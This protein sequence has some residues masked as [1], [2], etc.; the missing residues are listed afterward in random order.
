MTRKTAM[1]AHRKIYLHWSATDYDWAQPGHYHSVVNGDGVVQRMHDYNMDLTAHT[2]HRNTNSIGIACACMGGLHDPWT[3]PPKS[4]QL[5][6]MCR[7]VARIITNWGWSE[8]E[9]TVH[10]ILTHA[11]AAANRDGVVMHENYGPVA[12]G[13]TGERWDFMCLTK[14]GPDTGGDKI[15]EM[16]RHYYRELQSG[17]ADSPTSVSNPLADSVPKEMSAK[18]ETLK[19]LLDANGT[20]W[21]KVSELLSLYKI[22]FM[23][24]ADKRR[25][26]LGS[27]SITPR[28]SQDQVDPKPGVPSFDLTLQGA[29]SPVILVG[30]VYDNSAYCR[31]LEFAEELGISASFNPFALQEMRGG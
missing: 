31:V 11:E 14:N 6:A 7:E 15:R 23:W 5:E 22:P 1:T 18:G 9:I 30:L 19:V 10:N 28:Y 26:L 21:A 2:Y 12:W 13:G 24:D 20:S 16:I 25:I 3:M 8:A 17:G 29:N 4:V 27:S